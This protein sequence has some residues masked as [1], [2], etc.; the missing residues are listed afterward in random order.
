[1]RRLLNEKKTHK[2]SRTINS[3]LF[4]III[5]VLYS[6]AVVAPLVNDDMCFSRLGKDTYG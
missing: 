3:S 4:T 5:V 2:I 1:M 6:V